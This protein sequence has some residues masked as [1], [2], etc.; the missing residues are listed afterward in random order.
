MGVDDR[1]RP[2]MSSDADDLLASEVRRIMSVAQQNHKAVLGFA[3]TEQISSAN[4]K[5]RYRQLMKVLHPDKRSAVGEAHCGGKEVCDKAMDRVQKAE[6]AL[7]HG[8]QPLSQPQ[9]MWPSNTSSQSQHT[10]PT[11]APS[12]QHGRP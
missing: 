5:S 7:I 8:K 11:S 1:T 6:Q 9:H 12:Q 4:A 2:R 3:N 10:R